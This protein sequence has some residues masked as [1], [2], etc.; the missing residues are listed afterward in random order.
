MSGLQPLGTGV[1]RGLWP[2]CAPR[3]TVQ[4]PCWTSG[5]SCAA[6]MWRW[7]CGMTTLARADWRQSAAMWSF[8]HVWLIEW[9]KAKWRCIALRQPSTCHLNNRA[10]RCC[11]AC[12]C[13]TLRSFQTV[14][15]PRGRLGKSPARRCHFVASHVLRCKVQCTNR[16]TDPCTAA[17]LVSFLNSVRRGH[18]VEG[19]EHSLQKPCKCG[20]CWHCTVPPGGAHA[21]VSRSMAI[22]RP[23]R[24]WMWM[25][26]FVRCLSGC[27]R[28]WSGGCSAALHRSWL[29]GGRHLVPLPLLPGTCMVVCGDGR[30]RR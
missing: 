24:G 14:S 26:R 12:H 5:Q 17:R 4:H 1:P 2:T 7:C 22:G 9:S 3:C 21:S 11:P 29:L 23:C 30:P 6:Q 20:L 8:G 10:T 15:R 18:L 25:S 16:R 28:T 19:P 13:S 27:L